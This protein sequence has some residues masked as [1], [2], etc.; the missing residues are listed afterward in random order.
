[1]R[2]HCTRSAGLA[3]FKTCGLS[4]SPYHSPTS[5]KGRRSLRALRYGTRALAS[6]SGRP[7]VGVC[8]G[9]AGRR[10]APVYRKE[11]RP[12]ARHRHPA[13]P[14]SGLPGHCRRHQRLHLSSRRQHHPR[15][16]A[17][18]RRGEAVFSMCRVEPGRL[19]FEPRRPVAR[20]RADRAAVLDGLAHRIFRPAAARGA[21]CIPLSALPDRPALPL[22]V[23]RV[24]LR[25]TVGGQQ[26][27]RRR[28]AGGLLRHPV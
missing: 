19:R 18:G 8:A 16:P 10:P 3:L 21:V 27:S 1:M 12:L 20:V 25:D 28:A 2:S 7:N 11:A 23:R 24:T 14:L 17:L 13:G 22:P 5:P 15:R 26:P 9:A 6:N 4:L